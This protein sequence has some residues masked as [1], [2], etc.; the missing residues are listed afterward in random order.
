MVFINEWLPNPE[1][2][3]AA[4]EW[5]ELW[6][7]D[8]A[9][10]DVGGWKIAADAKAAFTLPSRTL[11]P[12]GY[13]V[14]ARKESKLTLKNTDGQLALYDARG[15]FVDALAFVGSA[16]E[17]KSVNRIGDGRGGGFAFGNPTPGALNEAA[18]LSA[19]AGV[20]ALPLGAHVANTLS[21]AEAAWLIVFGAAAIAGFVTY[22]VKTN[23]YLSELFFGKN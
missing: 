23:G 15:R 10:V 4:G 9:P 21:S 8:S 20:D 19:L 13:L 17:G 2:Q 22:A 5:I 3:D 16:P 6:N 1:G 11:S 7:D 12:D 18:P 14:I